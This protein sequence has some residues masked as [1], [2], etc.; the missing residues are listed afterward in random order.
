M[1]KFLWKVV[2]IVQGSYKKL[3]N[4]RKKIIIEKNEIL[5]K[6][7]LQLFMSYFLQKECNSLGNL[8]FR[9]SSS[10]FPESLPL[11]WKCVREVEEGGGLSANKFIKRL[12][13]KQLNFCFFELLHKL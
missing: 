4:F 8:F 13:R 9:A 5:T 2:K 10:K 12:P 6:I 3:M 11:L 7:D 1:G